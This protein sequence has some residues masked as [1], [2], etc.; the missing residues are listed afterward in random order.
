MAAVEEGI[1]SGLFS[2]AKSMMQVAANEKLDVVSLVA[3]TYSALCL[4]SGG[5]LFSI[6][7][8]MKTFPHFIGV[9]YT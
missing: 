1:T 7:W 5:E 3:N 2:G 8:V 6:Y 9:D 4:Q